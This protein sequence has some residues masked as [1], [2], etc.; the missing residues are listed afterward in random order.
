MRKYLQG[1]VLSVWCSLLAQQMNAVLVQ[2]FP[3]AHGPDGQ[4]FV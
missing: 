4:G 3:V 2:A 1:F